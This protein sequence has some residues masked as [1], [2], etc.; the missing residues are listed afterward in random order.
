M[1]DRL[2]GFADAAGVDPAAYRSELLPPFARVPDHPHLFDWCV[3]PRAGIDHDPG[4]QHWKRQPLERAGL[5]H[6]VFAGQIIAASRHDLNH[7]LGEHITRNNQT[8]RLACAWNISIYK[9]GPVT[10][11]WIIG[12]QRIITLQRDTRRKQ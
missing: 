11:S 5:P 6:D 10:V 9:R 1:E 12:D 4:D 8:V 2:E 7:H 3:V